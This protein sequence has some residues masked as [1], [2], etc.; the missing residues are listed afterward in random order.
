MM[1]DNLSYL[2]YFYFSPSKFEKISP[3][4]N[5]QKMV[6]YNREKERNK[7]IDNVTISGRRLRRRIYKTLLI[8][9]V[10]LIYSY[11]LAFVI[12]N[13][14]NITITTTVITRIQI[15]AVFL[16]LWALLGQLG[17]SIQTFKGLT[18]PEYINDLW[19]RVLNVISAHLVLFGYFFKM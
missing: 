10:V 12:K 15:F 14:T 8:M 17:W 3:D 2:F 18:A 19:F 6:E 4:Y 9:V 5:K 7:N 13:Y 1:G 16:V 11:V